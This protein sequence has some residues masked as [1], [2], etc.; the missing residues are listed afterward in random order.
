VIRW[1]LVVAATVVACVLAAGVKLYR[2][3]REPW[4]F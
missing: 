4:A 3:L 1:P 2:V